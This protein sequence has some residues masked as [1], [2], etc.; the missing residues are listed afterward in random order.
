MFPPIDYNRVFTRIPEIMG[1]ELTFNKNWWEGAYYINGEP[2]KQRDKLKVK[3]QK[4]LVIAYEQGGPS[5][6]LPNWLVTYG[7]CADYKAAFEVIRGADKPVTTPVAR[8]RKQTP[9]LYV[10]RSDYEAMRE[11]DLH[12]CPLFRWMSGLFG[13][14]NVRATWLRYN[15]C[16][17][18]LGRAVFWYVD[19]EGRILH[20]KRIA[21][22]YDG[23]R[24]RKYGAS[25]QYKVGDG[26]IGRCLFGE[27]LI[28]DADVINVVESEK[29]A[30]LASSMWGIRKGLWIATGGKSNIGLIS[31]IKGKNIR[32]FPDMDAADEWA[33]HGDVV[34]WWKGF[35]LD[36]HSDIGDL[37]VKLKKK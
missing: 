4:G 25:R 27:H 9:T 8:T 12:A 18:S 19:K 21:Y 26:Y 31:D 7:G 15:V 20:D 22:L 10:P 2:H 13:E 6:T 14:N 34:E 23:H 35:E 17:D 5:L 3:L 16:T 36:E 32:L 24:N 33:K 1:L 30:L 37:V 29:S 28:A 11:F